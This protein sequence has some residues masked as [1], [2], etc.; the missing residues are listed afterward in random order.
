MTARS[1]SPLRCAAFFGG[2]YNNAYA[3]KEAIR[4]ARTR[5]AEAMFCL[6]DLGGFG[7]HPERSPA[8]RN[9]SGVSVS[10]GN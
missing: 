7:P 1:P 8:I 4:D 3:L 10:Q 9:S 5:G 2:V 6:G